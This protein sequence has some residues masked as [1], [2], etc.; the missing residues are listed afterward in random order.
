MCT[1]SLQLHLDAIQF[2]VYPPLNS[3]GIIFLRDG[4]NHTMLEI[5]VH[6]TVQRNFNCAL[7]GSIVDGAAASVGAAGAL[8][9]AS[10]GA[11][12]ADAATLPPAA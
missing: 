5:S 6:N 7:P 12:V 4:G 9:S 10:P 2:Q 8:V 1:G 3:K 11:S